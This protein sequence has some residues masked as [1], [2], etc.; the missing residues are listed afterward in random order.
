MRSAR[1]AVVSRC[2]TTRVVRAAVSS[3]IA[4]FSAAFAA[5]SSAAVA[6]SSSRIAGS[7]SCALP[8][9]WAAAGRNQLTTLPREIGQFTS[10][11]NLVL[12]SN[13]L[14][15]LP[16]QIGRLTS[17]QLL[18]LRG[19][20][21]TALP[22][23]I[24]D[25]LD[26]GL[27][28]ELDDNPLT[29]PLPELI[30][31]GANAVAVY[32]RSLRSASGPQ[33]SAITRPLQSQIDQASTA[34]RELA[35]AGRTVSRRVLRRADVRGSNETLNALA[36]TINAELGGTSTGDGWTRHRPAW[37]AGRQVIWTTKAPPQARPM[38][39]PESR[40]PATLCDHEGV[41]RGTAARW[42]TCYL[43]RLIAPG[44]LACLEF[45]GFW[46]AL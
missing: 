37:P 15:A 1:A 10:L 2:A 6:S 35:P 4:R 34:A 22:P 23:K 30:Q 40:G 42:K 29:E 36:R 32:L 17:L 31:Q 45:L 9:R 8:A 12:Y 24:A 11:Q 21:L 13:Q 46:P 20:Q 43:V 28:T 5:R 38:P 41:P 7:A 26:G 33:D 25:R 44:R 27:I 19:N 16:P 3:L 18:D 14:A 39:V